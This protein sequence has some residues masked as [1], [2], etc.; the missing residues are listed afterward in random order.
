MI[1]TILDAFGF[2]L[3]EQGE[4]QRPFWLASQ[5]MEGR[6]WKASGHDVRAALE[7]D[8]KEW[9]EKSQFVKLA[10]DEYPLRLWSKS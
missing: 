5:M 2:A 9:V 7:T 4:P 10:E 8:M 1:Y 3:E 6:L